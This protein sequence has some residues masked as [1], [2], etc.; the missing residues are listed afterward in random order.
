MIAVREIVLIAGGTG[1]IGRS[2]CERLSEAGYEVRLLSRTSAQSDRFRVFLWQPD[3]GEVDEAVFEAVKYIINLAGVN[4]GDKR[5]SA[6]RKEAIRASRINATSLLLKSVSKNPG[7]IRLYIGASAVGYYGAVTKHHEFVETDP[8]GDDFLG[9]TCAE[10]EAASLG[11]ENPGV[12]RV[13]LRTGVVLAPDAGIIGK[14][15]P[16]VRFGLGAVV[17]TG[18]QI[19]PWIH[20]EDLCDLY[21]RAIKDETMEGIY[22]AVAPTATTYR[23]FIVTFAKR[24]NRSIWLPAVPE[25]MIHLVLGEMSVML[26]RGSAVSA[27]KILNQG[28]KFQHPDLVSALDSVV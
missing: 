11:F 9:A 16:S 21:L 19:V 13:L 7:G 25:W 22:N 6:K 14:L 10:W 15:K 23:E 28:F 3:N 17:G 27:Q 5:W 4:I 12:R 18:D 20:L 2:L 1:L 26:C 8:A 24:M